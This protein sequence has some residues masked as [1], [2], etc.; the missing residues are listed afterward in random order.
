MTDEHLRLQSESLYHRSPRCD[1]CVGHLNKCVAHGA[2]LCCCS[3]DSQC[4]PPPPTCRHRSTQSHSLRHGP[5]V[6]LDVASWMAV[7][8]GQAQ[9][10]RGDRCTQA[11][12]TS[13]ASVR[14]HG[15]AHSSQN[16]TLSS[17]PLLFRRPAYHLLHCSC[18]PVFYELSLDQASTSY[19]TRVPGLRH[20]ATHQKQKISPPQKRRH[21]T[22]NLPRGM[23]NAV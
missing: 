19:E 10:P 1:T 16:T 15:R 21:L 2:H 11:P 8:V 13:A 7:L 14:R 12:A 20:L 9:V 17:F 6:S 18:R 5:Q 23:Q 22:T 4:R 3:I